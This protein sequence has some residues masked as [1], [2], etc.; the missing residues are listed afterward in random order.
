M[1]KSH[2]L[3]INTYIH[4][5]TY[6]QTYIYVYIHTYIHTHTYTHT[7]SHTYI[8]RERVAVLDSGHFIIARADLTKIPVISAKIGAVQSNV[9]ADFLY[10]YICVRTGRSIVYA[11]IL[12]HEYTYIHVP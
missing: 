12:T 8:P 5:L 3:L 11:T 1:L 4:I 6:T 10:M 7:H 2:N 9:N